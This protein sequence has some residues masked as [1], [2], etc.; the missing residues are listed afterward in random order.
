MGNQWVCM[1]LRL[2]IHVYLH[3][4]LMIASKKTVIDRCFHFHLIHTS[5]HLWLGLKTQTD[6]NQFNNWSKLSTFKFHQ[7]T[8]RRTH[9]SYT[10]SGVYFI[11]TIIPKTASH[12]DTQTVCIGIR[13]QLLFQYIYH[14][15]FWLLEN[16]T[17]LRTPNKCQIQI[18]WH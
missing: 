5:L 17:T 8:L 7:F 2:Y 1:N 11:F 4:Y 18:D 12:I 3:K 9:I 6:V 14:I 13:P 16:S 15:A 10:W